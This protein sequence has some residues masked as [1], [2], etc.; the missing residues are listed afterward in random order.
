[1]CNSADNSACGSDVD[2][3]LRHE[4]QTSKA[5]IGAEEWFWGLMEHLVL[6]SFCSFWQNSFYR[7]RRGGFLHVENNSMF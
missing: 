5:V 7:G 1:M 4:A 2:Q 6:P 3:L